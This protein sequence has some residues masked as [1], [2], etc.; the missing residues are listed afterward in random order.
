MGKKRTP[1]AAALKYREELEAKAAEATRAELEKQGLKALKPGEVPPPFVPPPPSPGAGPGVDLRLDRPAAP[2]ADRWLG[3]AMGAAEAP[4][5]G[6]R[7]WALRRRAV[8][9]GR[10]ADPAGSARAA[11]FAGAVDRP[12]ARRFVG[13][14]DGARAL[15]P[16]TASEAHDEDGAVVGMGAGIPG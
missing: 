9:S 13:P 5:R 7:S 3:E 16:M 6:A 12:G 15:A 8:V 1:S 11:A 14:A 2:L 10:W 4:G